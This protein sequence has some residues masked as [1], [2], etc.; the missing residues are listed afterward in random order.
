MTQLDLLSTP[1]APARHDTA[2]PQLRSDDWVE[3]SGLGIRFDKRHPFDEALFAAIRRELAGG[4]RDWPH[5]HRRF[6]GR[7]GTFALKAHLYR[8]ASTGE[9]EERPKY[10]GSSNPR[11]PWYLGWTGE[12]RITEAA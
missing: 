1:A 11:D 8:L 12:Y 6:A 5:L 3:P 10:W 2:P 7:F 9:I 4:P